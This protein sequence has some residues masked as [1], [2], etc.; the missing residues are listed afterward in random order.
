MI[1][2]RRPLGIAASRV[3]FF[4]AFAA[5]KLRTRMMLTLLAVGMFITMTLSGSVGAQDAMGSGMPEV[6]AP[7]DPSPGTPASLTEQPQIS[8]KTMNEVLGAVVSTITDAFKALVNNDSLTGVGKTLT[9]SMFAIMFAWSLLKSMVQGDGINGII[10]ELVPLVATVAVITALI[11]GKGVGAIVGFMDGVAGAFGGGG[12]LGPDIQ[13]AGKTGFTAIMNVLTMPSPNTKVEL[14]LS[15]IGMA[16]GILG[17]Y[18]LGLIAKILTSFIIVVAVAIYMANVVLAHGSIMLAQATAALMIPFL[19]V[20]SLSFIFEG[21]LRFTLGAGMIKVVG[22]F[23]IAFTSKLMGGLAMLS[24]KVQV[25]ADTDFASLA[26][27]NLI[28]YCGLILM[29]FLAAYMMMQVPSLATGLLSGSAGGAGFKGMR[30]LT[31]GV[32][33]QV[34]SAA[35]SAASRPV[36]QAASDGA[37]AAGRATSGVARGAYNAMR[38]TAHQTP[39]TRAAAKAAKAAQTAATNA[40]MT[41]SQAY[42]AAGGAVFKKLG[43]NLL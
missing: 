14:G 28:I 15:N 31:G 37:R 13:A 33:F 1:L 38:G 6:N 39:P 19:L 20:P 34:G 24:Q 36:V 25:P 9:Y 43:G 8:P 32:G 12:G 40:S 18:L 35:G 16:I 22:A 4:A 30:A 17:L 7:A 26:A 3:D 11:D 21:W 42:G 5:L 10:S 27:T 29:A 2:I 41:P 23:M